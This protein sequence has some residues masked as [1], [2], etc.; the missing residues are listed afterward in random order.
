MGERAAAWQAYRAKQGGT[1]TTR[2]ILGYRRVDGQLLVD[3]QT[4][5]IVK[6]AVE[7]LLESGSLSAAAGFLRDGGHPKHLSAYSSLLS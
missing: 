2:A 5:P 1:P 7:I 3:E 4:A 6:Q